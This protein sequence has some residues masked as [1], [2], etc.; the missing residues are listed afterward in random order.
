[1]PPSPALPDCWLYLIRHAATANNEQRPSRLQGRRSNPPLTPSGLVQAQRTAAQ[2]S[3]LPLSAIY[4]S[5]LVRARQTAEAI[6]RPHQLPVQEVQDLIEV[7]VGIWEGST[8]EDI[9]RDYPVEYRRFMTTPGTQPYVGGENLGQ[10]QQ[11]VTPA[12]ERLMQQHRGKRIAV[13]AH[14]VVNRAFLSTLLQLPIDAARSIVQDNC[15]INI[16]RLREDQLQLRTC[17]ATLHLP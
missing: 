3:R 6:A 8:W 16:I 10:V 11:R 5:P 15:G 14:N 1:M 2:L 4:S 17:N 7:D 9:A 13:I 12:I